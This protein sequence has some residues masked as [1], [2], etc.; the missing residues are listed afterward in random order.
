[1][2]Y[3]MKNSEEMILVD[4]NQAWPGVYLVKY[5]CFYY[6]LKLNSPVLIVF[7]VQPYISLNALKKCTLL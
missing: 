1:M 5:Y 6:F 4:F 3:N 2:N 7:G